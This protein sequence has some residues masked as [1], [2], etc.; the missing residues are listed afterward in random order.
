LLKRGEEN[1]PPGGGQEKSF[2]GDPRGLRGENF[3][4][5]VRPQ[6]PREQFV[7]FIQ[8]GE[9]RANSKYEEDAASQVP[10]PK[11]KRF[12]GPA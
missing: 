7:L 6:K 12:Q 2:G 1:D 4:K 11:E 3:K 5:E 9:K 8:D 10:T